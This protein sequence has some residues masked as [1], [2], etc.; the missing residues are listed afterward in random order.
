[1]ENKINT[2]PTP[3]TGLGLEWRPARREDAP[4]LH[5]LFLDVEAV[6]HRGHHSSLEDR[7]HN[8]EEPDWNPETDSLV[9]FTPQGKIAAMTFVYLPLSTSVHELAAWMWGEVH[10]DFRR[11]GFGRFL[12][13][14]GEAN[15][16]PRLQAL[17]GDLP[18]LIK[19]NSPDHLSDRIALF[20][21]SG[22][23]PARSF[24]WMRRSL[25]QPVETPAFPDGFQ[26]LSWSQAWD[27]KIRLAF[28]DSFSEHW[29][30]EP[31]DAEMWR[32]LIIEA[33]DFRPDF[34][35]F[36]VDGQE[37]AAFTINEVRA[38]ELDGKMLRQG[39]I[40]DIGTPRR[41]RKRG[42]AS[43]LINHSLLAFQRAGLKYAGLGVDSENATGAL[44]LYERLGF[45]VTDRSTQ[46]V[47]MVK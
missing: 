12:L 29:G 37:V 45:Q 27:E 20:G 30:F 16:I 39:W 7:Y 38:L 5:Q 6:D 11:Q 41:W 42:L 25:E 46:Y 32:V 26:V 22:Y 14:W 24:Y 33:S 3:P 2:L 9:A 21:R 8:F 15:L 40:R 44:R 35:F 36:V 4:A 28:N 19:V 43:A 23:H 18:R 10:P 31:L 34:S 13:S 1:M 47:K 17:P